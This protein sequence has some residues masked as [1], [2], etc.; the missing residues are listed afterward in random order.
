MHGWSL[1]NELEVLREEVG[2]AKKKGKHHLGK[3]TLA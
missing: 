1:F 2:G 3:C